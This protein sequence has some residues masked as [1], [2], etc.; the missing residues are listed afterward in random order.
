MFYVILFGDQFSLVL[1]EFSFETAFHEG[2]NIFNITDGKTG[3]V[4]TS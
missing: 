1:P 3:N 4:R 2:L